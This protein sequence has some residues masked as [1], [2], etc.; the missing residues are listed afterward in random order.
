MKQEVLSNFEWIY[1]SVFG[2]LLFL[3]LFLG[4]LAWIWRKDSKKTY[5]EASRLPFQEGELQ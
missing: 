2:L 3:T 1:L 4:M 5:E